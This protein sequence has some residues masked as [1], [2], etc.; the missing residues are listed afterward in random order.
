M[1]DKA[2]PHARKFSWQGR[3]QR[4]KDPATDAASITTI[5]YARKATVTMQRIGLTGGCDG[6]L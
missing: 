2:M 1:L 4:G 6:S 5:C 3:E